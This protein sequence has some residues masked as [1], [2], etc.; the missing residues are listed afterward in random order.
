MDAIEDIENALN[1]SFPVASG[2]RVDDCRRLTGPGLLW[3]HAG[4]VLDVF[5]EGFEPELLIASWTRNARSVLD[6]V[7]WQSE[8]TTERLFDGGANLSISAP[9]DQLYSAVFVAQTIWH[10]CASELLGKEPN[11]FAP[12]ISDLT[13]VMK[14]ESNPALIAL[15]QAATDRQI[16]ALSDDDE[17]SL[18]H[19][20]GSNSWPVTDLP[21]PDEVD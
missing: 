5:F 1:I 17:L 8:Q 18:G 11:A 21:I 10:L 7:G 4:A 20:V 16:D 6:A 13:E 2:L 19:G 14:R 9:M 3:D 15:M 12:M